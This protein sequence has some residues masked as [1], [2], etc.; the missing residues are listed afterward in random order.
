MRSGLMRSLDK[1]ETKGFYVAR[2]C[3]G[4]SPATCARMEYRWKERAFQPGEVLVRQGHRPT[5]LLFIES[6]AAEG[7]SAFSHMARPYRDGEISDQVAAWW[8]RYVELYGV[9]PEYGA[10]GYRNADVVVK[11]LEAAGQDVTAEK[12]IAAIEAMTEYTDLFGYRLTFGP[13]DHQGVD[14]SVLLT[15]VDGRWQVQA[16]SIQ[17]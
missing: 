12:L 5:H 7:F 9:E 14:G 10:M 6:G 11:A 1:A 8:D 17:Y 16:Q 13:E 2:K 4:M 3:L 15:V